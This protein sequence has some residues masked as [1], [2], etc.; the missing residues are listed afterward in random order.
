MVFSLA[1]VKIWYV[2]LLWEKTEVVANMYN[3]VLTKPQKVPGEFF[4]YIFLQI[5]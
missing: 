3:V 2:S 5:L 4:Y 1:E